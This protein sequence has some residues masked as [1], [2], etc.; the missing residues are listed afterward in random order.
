MTANKAIR[1][2]RLYLLSDMPLEEPYLSIY[3]ELENEFSNLNKFRT[4]IGQSFKNDIMYGKNKNDIRIIY[5]RGSINMLYIDS[6]VKIGMVLKYK[7]E[8]SEL[9]LIVKWFIEKEYIIKIDDTNSLIFSIYL[10]MTKFE[11]V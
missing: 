8:Q 1:N 3:Q 5:E 2:F 10:D 9:Y 7:I 4:R 6:N 11:L